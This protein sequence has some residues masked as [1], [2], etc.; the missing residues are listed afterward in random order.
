[1]LV[2]VFIFEGTSI[3]FSIVAVSIYTPTNRG[4]GSGVGGIGKLG[5]T[6]IHY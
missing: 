5:L 2:L 6:H 1:M 4:V 3:L